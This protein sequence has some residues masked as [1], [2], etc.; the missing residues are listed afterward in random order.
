MFVIPLSQ[1]VSNINVIA[2]ENIILL[3]DSSLSVRPSGIF[4]LLSQ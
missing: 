2:E 1:I 4:F 3:T